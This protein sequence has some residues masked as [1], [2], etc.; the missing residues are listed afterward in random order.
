MKPLNLSGRMMKR[1]HIRSEWS[2]IDLAQRS[3]KELIMVS[4]KY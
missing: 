1:N 3:P 2:D 4:N